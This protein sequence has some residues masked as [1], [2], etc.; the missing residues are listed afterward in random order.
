M[1][2]FLDPVGRCSLLVLGGLQQG[3]LCL[4]SLL[5]L[6]PFLLYGCVC[7]CVCAHSCMHVHVCVRVQMPWAPLWFRGGF[8]DSGEADLREALVGVVTLLC[9]PSW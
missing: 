6:P 7:V 2:F 4:L 9:C 5:L 1:F 3:K 8:L